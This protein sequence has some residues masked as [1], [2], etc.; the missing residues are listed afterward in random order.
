[1]ALWLVL[2]VVAGGWL[3]ARDRTIF[4][5]TRYFIFLVPALCLAWGR[6]LGWLWGQWRPAGVA[7]L[8]L[9]FGVVLVAL[10]ADWSAEN[11]REAWRESQSGPNDAVLVEPDYVYP[12]L[13]RYLLASRPI[14]YPF[15]DRL[16]DP[17]VVDAPLEGLR[18]YDAVWLVQSHHQELDPSELV[19]SWFSTRYPLIT[20]AYPAGIV[21]RAFAQHYRSSVLPPGVSPMH[22]DLGKLQLLGCTVEPRSLKARDDLYHPPSGWVH[23]KTYWTTSTSL[24]EDVYPDVR[25]VD[26]AGQVW[27]ESLERLAD[28][29]HRWPTS[30]W[31]PGEIVRL[32]YDVNLNPITPAGAY[33]VTVNA[34]GGTSQVPCGDVEVTR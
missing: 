20:E 3:L 12:A 26:S 25:L 28:A 7:G 34:P 24:E 33:R 2:P 13:T 6:A 27:G 32:D 14:Y 30:R 11:R 22:A 10:P 4:T 21:L 23:A 29:I 16:D 9:A 1:M 5:E 19:A 15:T 8:V 31:Q 18:G 17:A